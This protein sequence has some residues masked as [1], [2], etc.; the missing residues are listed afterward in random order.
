[1]MDKAI[2]CPVC[3]HSVQLSPAS[4]PLAAWFECPTCGTESHHVMADPGK[5][6]EQ[7]DPDRQPDS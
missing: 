7:S 2:R 6:D 1:M 4:G 5:R 3:G